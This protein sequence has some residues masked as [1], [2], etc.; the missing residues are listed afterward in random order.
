MAHGNKDWTR[1][2]WI[3]LS[4]ISLN[5]TPGSYVGQ[6]LKIVRVNAGETALEFFVS[7]GD[8]PSGE[9]ILF[10]KDTA[11]TGYTLLI[12]KDDMVVFITK[13][14]AAGGEQGGTDK[15]GGTWT[16]PNHAH[17]QADGWD[18]VQYLTYKNQ[19]GSSYTSYYRGAAGL[20]TYGVA[21]TAWRTDV[22]ATVNTW[23]PSGRNFTRQQRN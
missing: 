21:S 11:V 12:N 3:P 7:G 10:E 9:I 22:A 1:E 2:V 6:S 8:V 13:G 23:R 5:D 15:I 16:Q 14:T 20:A 19:T 4:F 18:G 17:D